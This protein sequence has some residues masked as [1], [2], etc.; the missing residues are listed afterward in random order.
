VSTTRFIHSNEIFSG[1]PLDTCTVLNPQLSKIKS[2]SKPWSTWISLYAILQTIVLSS[3]G[4]SISLT[5]AQSLFSVTTEVSSDIATHLPSLPLQHQ[6]LYG[7]YVNYSHNN[8]AAVPPRQYYSQ[9]KVIRLDNNHIQSQ[10][11]DA[12]VLA[13]MVN[14]TELHLHNNLLT[15]LPRQVANWNWTNLQAIHLY[16]NPWSCDCN[17]QWMK[18]WLKT[19]G[20]AVVNLNAITCSTDDIRNGRSLIDVRNEDF[21]CGH[22]M[23]T[24]E[25]IWVV[26]TIVTASVFGVVVVTLVTLYKKRK[27]LYK[28]FQLHPF[29][30]DECEGEDMTYDVFLSGARRRY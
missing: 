22:I 18:D 16:G 21:V 7:Y 17:S 8:I 20:H 3:V 1:Q 5:R 27:W 6:L 29:D 10:S 23:S 24:N 19:L 11:I 13:S 4:V 12:D 9:S 15:S 26:V 25:I 30:V 2:L 28:R 14:V